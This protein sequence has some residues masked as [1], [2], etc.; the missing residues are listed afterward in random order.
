MCPMTYR[1]LKH[2]VS[3]RE[4]EQLMSS[5]LRKGKAPATEHEDVSSYCRVD[6]LELLVTQD[7]AIAIESPPNSEAD[8]FAMWWWVIA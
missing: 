8:T 4:P 6:I 5:D 7:T 1:W 3:T 2:P